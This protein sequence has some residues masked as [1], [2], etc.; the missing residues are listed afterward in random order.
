MSHRF[1]LS[2]AWLAAV[3]LLPG[4]GALHWVPWKRKKPPRAIAEYSQFV[5]TWWLW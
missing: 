3:V 4:C 1:R 2:A 5:G